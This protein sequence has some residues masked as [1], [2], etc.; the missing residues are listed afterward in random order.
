MGQGFCSWATPLFIA[1]FHAPA[2]QSGKSHTL[3][4]VLPALVATHGLRTRKDATS[5]KID[6][7][8]GLLPAIRPNEPPLQATF[9]TLDCSTFSR[10]R[11]RDCV[12]VL[13]HLS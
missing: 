7:S 8:K 9:T 4:Y 10:D 12:E 5:P 6:A 3:N 11:C 1:L 2:L 13:T